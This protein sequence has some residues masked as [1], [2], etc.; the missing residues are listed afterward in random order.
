[1]SRIPHDQKTH[2]LARRALIRA[3]E[4]ARIVCMM[5]DESTIKTPKRDRKAWHRLGIRAALFA[6]SVLSIPGVV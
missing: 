6:V 3:K 4:S 1:M 2:K 5:P